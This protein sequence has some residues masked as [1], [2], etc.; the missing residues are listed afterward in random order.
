M[1]IKAIAQSAVSFSDI[2]QDRDKISTPEIIQAYPDGIHIDE[3]EYVTMTKTTVDENGKEVE[4]KDTFWAYHFIEED[5]KFAF[6]G[7][8]LAKIFDKI[9]EACEGDVEKFNEE[10]KAQTLH[11]KLMHGRTQSKRPIFLVDVV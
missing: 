7:A 3:A 1:N 6:A 9:M 5:S 10:L 8:L 2:M 4:Y 11:V